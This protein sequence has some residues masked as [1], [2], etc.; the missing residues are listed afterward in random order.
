MRQL[1]KMATLSVDDKG[2]AHSNNNE[3]DA[4]AE[5]AEAKEASSSAKESKS[6]ASGA[7]GV[8]RP[9]W[10]LTEEAAKTAAEDKLQGDEADL[11]AFA[12]G[13]DFERYIGDMEV[14]TMMERLRW[15]IGQ[16]EK[17]V[18]SDDKRETDGAQRAAKRELL[19]QMVRTSLLMLIMSHKS[20]GFRRVLICFSFSS[21]VWRK[22]VISG[23]GLF[24][25]ISIFT[26]LL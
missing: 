14:Q 13:L 6:S 8:H 16:L 5:V 26:I 10:A 9:A 22:S 17:E 2:G 19:A 23:L 20:E 15:R 21:L 12:E 25:H 11:I 24:L 1:A 4:A 7:K 3:N 18:E